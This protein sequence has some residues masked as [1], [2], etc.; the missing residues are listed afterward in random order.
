MLRRV[1]FWCLVAIIVLAPLPLG[2]NRPWSWSLLAVVV[3]VLCLLWPWA[4]AADRR[5]PLADLR[6]LAVPAAL[7]LA[8]VAWALL[9]SSPLLPHNWAAALFGDAAAALG[10]TG[11]DA[12]QP[13][14][15]LE[16]ATGV[17]RL[18]CYA[19]VFWL[20]FQ[21]GRSE[22][23]ARW[24]VEAMAVAGCAYAVYGLAVFASGNESILLMR[25][26]AYPSSL[27]ST[28]VN[29]NTYA[30]YAGLTILCAMYAAAR[31]IERPVRLRGLLLH[32]RRPTILFA[33]TVPIITA[34]LLASGSRAGTASLILGMTVLVGTLRASAYPPG[35]DR[36][37]A[38]LAGTAVACG[39]FAML[40]GILSWPDALDGDFSDRLRL[41]GLTLELIEQ[42]PWT[43]YGLGGFA[44]AFAMIRPPDVALLWTEA[45]NTYLE[46]AVD[47]GMPAAAML[48]A[49]VLWLFGMCVAGVMLRRRDAGFPALG[50]AATVLVGFHALFDFSLQIPGLTV[51][52]AAVLGV[53]VAQSYG[54]A[55]DRPD[56]R[57]LTR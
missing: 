29:R 56:L 39:L 1:H 22:R 4:F 27:T 6:R 16:V 20:A 11:T 25:K 2:S 49:A 34:A 41:W 44:S 15:R 32:F 23:R 42:R 21:H 43:G 48:I 26:W 19:G 24:L 38:F 9:Q 3:G 8:V 46:L 17:M 53:A 13:A 45:H 10:V 40:I 50:V 14:F 30:T 47:L 52:W 35:P 37:K 57:P 18:L 31:R 7:F 28:F 55:A 12:V 36:R 5:A 33:L 54:T 51:V